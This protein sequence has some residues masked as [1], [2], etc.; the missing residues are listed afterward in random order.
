MEKAAPV[1]NT[2]AIPNAANKILKCRNLLALREGMD[3]AV[4]VLRLSAVTLVEQ[5]TSEMS[6]LPSGIDT[7][8][9]RIANIRP[10][11]VAPVWIESQIKLNA[12][13]PA[14]ENE[15]KAIW[16]RLCDEFLELDFVRQ[17]HHAFKFDTVDALRLAIKISDRTSFS[18]ISGLVDWLREK[19]GA[20]QAPARRQ[21]IDAPHTEAIDEPSVGS[22]FV[23]CQA[24]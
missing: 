9:R 3:L 19:T 21:D 6:E 23:S 10:L 5:P 4:S 20:D 2:A 14:L 16:D 1:A 12:G 24:G 18:T 17:A 11:M 15:L 22:V 7:S 8:L 13:S